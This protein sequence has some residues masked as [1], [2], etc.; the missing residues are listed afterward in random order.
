MPRTDP[1]D[2]AHHDAVIVLGDGPH[3]TLLDTRQALLLEQLRALHLA[4]SSD[5]LALEL[6]GR[7]NRS[8][9][10]VNILCLTTIDDAARIAASIVASIIRIAGSR[11]LQ[12]FITAMDA[13]DRAEQ[14]R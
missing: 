1:R 8:D 6:Q 4:E 12:A 14:G 5:A 7:V 9:D 11:G 2:V 13:V 10:Q 3:E